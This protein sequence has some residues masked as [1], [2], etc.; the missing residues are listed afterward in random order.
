MIGTEPFLEKF[1]W[2]TSQDNSYQCCV[3]EPN[4]QAEFRNLV[5]HIKKHGYVLTVQGKSYVSV[6]I[7]EYLYWTIWDSLEETN[8]VNRMEISQERAKAGYTQE[9]DYKVDVMYR[10]IFEWILHPYGFKRS[11][12]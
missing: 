6:D 11:V 3:C 7:G 9:Y 10:N 4:N 12:K 8:F 2:E 5:I 1:H